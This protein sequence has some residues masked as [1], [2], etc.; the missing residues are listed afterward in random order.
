MYV[1][2]DFE[3]TVFY[4]CILCWPA[5]EDIS[6]SSGIGFHR[7][8]TAVYILFHF[9]SFNIFGNNVTCKFIG[10]LIGLFDY[11]YRDCFGN[12]FV[13]LWCNCDGC[14]T[15]AYGFNVTLF[16]N[17]YYIF[18]VW[19]KGNA[20]VCRFV[21]DNRYGDF[22]A[23]SLWEGNILS[24]NL[25]INYGNL[26]RYSYSFGNWGIF[27]W[28]YCDCS[29]TFA[30]CN[31]IT[32]T[33]NLNYT[34]IA[35]FIDKLFVCSIL[36]DL[37]INILFFT[38]VESEVICYGKLRYGNLYRYGNFFLNILVVLRGNGDCSG[39]FTDCNDVAVFVNLY[40]GFIAWFVG[41]LLICCLDGFNLCYGY[42]ISLSLIETDFC[43]INSNICYGNFNRYGHCISL[44][45]VI[46]WCNG[47]CCGTL[48]YRS[49][50]AVFVNPYYGFIAWFVGNL[51]YCC[52]LGL[53]V[54]VDFCCFIYINSNVPAHNFN[55]FNRNLVEAV[56]HNIIFGHYKGIAHNLC[57]LGVPAYEY[58]F[59]NIRN[60]VNRHILAR[61]EPKLGI[62]NL[63]S[64][65]GKLVIFIVLILYS[66]KLDPWADKLNVV[67]DYEVAVSIN[68]CILCWPAWEDIVLSRSVIGNR[69]GCALLINCRVNNAY[70]IRNNITCK[71]IC[72]GIFGFLR[73]IGYIV[74]IAVVFS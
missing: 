27:L 62:G 40:H 23:V 69:Y 66:V 25:D 55:A 14:G 54:N 28:G 1:V 47:N 18:V 37:C 58:I 44:S 9:R 7:Y 21:G 24:F 49:D 20:F 16:V 42:F 41:N 22:V 36:I 35:W 73:L 2:C 12:W 72:N 45:R 39:T 19:L 29:G 38:Y 11:G 64:L 17:L 34:G 26:Y 46:N 6:V 74:K 13:I 65:C 56:E 50:V 15:L 53:Y 4:W 68:G 8:V 63:R 43:F 57:I 5:W 71:F 67:I 60:T 51:R 33:V 70:A 10:N 61:C 52:I 3:F 59:V 31:N 32:V 48:A 30:Y